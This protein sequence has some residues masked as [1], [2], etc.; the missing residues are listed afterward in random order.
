MIFRDIADKRRKFVTLKRSLSLSPVVVQKGVLMDMLHAQNLH[1][2]S[3]Y[4]YQMNRSIIRST[5]P[6]IVGCIGQT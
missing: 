1:G 6:L 5:H 2:T 3:S 4:I